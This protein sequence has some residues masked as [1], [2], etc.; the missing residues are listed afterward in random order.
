M[1]WK[2]ICP[3]NEEYL[4]IWAYLVTQMRKKGGNS[5]KLIYWIILHKWGLSAVYFSF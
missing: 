3:W 4:D 5:H 1:K 2:E